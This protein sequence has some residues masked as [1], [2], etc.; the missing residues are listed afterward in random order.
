MKR[1]SII[2]HTGIFWGC[3]NFNMNYVFSPTSFNTL[4]KNLHFKQSISPEVL[5]LCQKID[6][7]YRVSGKRNFEKHTS[8]FPLIV[9][10]TFKILG[11]ENMLFLDHLA[12]LSKNA[13]SKS[14]AIILTEKLEKGF[15]PDLVPTNIDHLCVLTKENNNKISIEVV[16]ELEKLLNEILIEEHTVS[17][18]ILNT[19][20]ITKRR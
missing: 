15:I 7:H 19:G 12:G 8:I 9:F 5:L 18:N 16:N 14:R 20:I 17:R 11:N 10:H 4:A 1:Q 6:L 2:N 3:G 13:F